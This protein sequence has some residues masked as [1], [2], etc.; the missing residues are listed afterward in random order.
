M[1]TEDWFSWDLKAHMLKRTH[2]FLSGLSLYVR[3]NI[4]E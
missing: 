4:M 3:L 2:Q 1:I